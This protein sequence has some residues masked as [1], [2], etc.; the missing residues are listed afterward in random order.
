MIESITVN[1]CASKS[2]ATFQMGY[3]V[4]INIKAQPNRIWTL[5][6]NAKDF[7][8]WNSTVKNIE[9]TISLGEK[10]QLRATIAPERIFKLRVSEFVVNQKM[11]WRDG[12]APMFQGVRTYA[13]K[14]KNDGSTDFLM[15]EIFSG[16]MLPMIVKSLP[17]FGP[18][19]EQY[20]ADL[21]HEAEQANR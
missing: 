2:K 13:L 7:P 16:L 15:E 3:A 21:K 11:V 5:L 18:T 9:G 4:G 20:T 8:R 14:S 19:F 6:T 12:A 1:G 17:D 10:I